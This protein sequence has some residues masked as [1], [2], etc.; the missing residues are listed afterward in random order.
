MDEW[1]A[2]DIS[3]RQK[4]MKSK[5]PKDGFVP[6]ASTAIRIA[7]A[8]AI[9]QWG[10]KQIAA[11]RPFKARLR[12]DVWT[13]KGTLHPQGVFGGTAVIQLSKINGAV[14]FAIHQY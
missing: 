2:L 14:L 10:E 9:A 4:S 1:T 6:D 5:P 7:E 13:I 11:E 8:V 12:G 3:L